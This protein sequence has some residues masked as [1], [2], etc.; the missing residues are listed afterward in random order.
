MPHGPAGTVM[1]VNAKGYYV[2]HSGKKKE[3]NRLLASKETDN[4]VA[5]YGKRTA[6]SIL[7]SRSDS[8]R[9]IDDEMIAHAPIMAGRSGMGSRYAILKSVPTSEFSYQCGFIR[10]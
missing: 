10:G 6:E 9:E 5:D 2:Y 4:L 7:S 8:F 1:L 3:W